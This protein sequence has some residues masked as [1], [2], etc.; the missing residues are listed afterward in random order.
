MANKLREF[1]LAKRLS[2]DTLAKLVG[3]C[4]VQISY[5]ETGKRKPADAEKVI[6]AAVLNT[7]VEELFDGPDT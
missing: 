4:Q 2:Q 1:R 7:T 5:F 6:M 3:V